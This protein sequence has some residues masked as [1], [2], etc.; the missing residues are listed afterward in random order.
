MKTSINVTRIALWASRLVSVVLFGLLFALPFLLD[1]YA[2]VRTLSS[3][4]HTAIMVAFYI[5]AAAAFLALAAMD[6]MLQSILSG[7]VFIRKNVHRI[8]I[9]QWCSA[10]IS[11]V[12]IPAAFIYYPL[13]FMVVIMGFLALTVCVLCRVMHEAVKIREE[14]DLTL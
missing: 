12:C 9:I 2:T 8:R 10:A 13:I 4:E 7:K 11:L 1:W 3:A 5:C 14:N 6:R